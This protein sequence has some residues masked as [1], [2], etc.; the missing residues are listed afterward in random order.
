MTEAVCRSTLLSIQG[1]FLIKVQ[2]VLIGY[3]KKYSPPQGD[4]TV[5]ISEAATA[6]EIIEYYQMN[7]GEVGL[8]TVNQK[9]ID[10]N[11]PLSPGVE[12][13]LYP[14]LGGG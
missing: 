5:E 11:T 2:V 10:I 8:V 1:G 12:L 7:P 14:L 6:R 13:V 3:L 4:G 9:V